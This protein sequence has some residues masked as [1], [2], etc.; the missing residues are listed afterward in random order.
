MAN[1][2]NLSLMRIASQNLKEEKQSL[3]N[4]VP[5]I[6]LTIQNNIKISVIYRVQKKIPAQT[7]DH[8]NNQAMIVDFNTKII[9]AL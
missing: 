5:R 8:L 3:I 6:N 2:I 1:I 9:K 7:K 4:R